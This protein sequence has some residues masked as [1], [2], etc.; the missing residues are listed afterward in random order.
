MATEG[1]ETRYFPAGTTIFREGDRTGREAF[2]I[3][4]GCVEIR[5]I[6][7]GLPHVLATLGPDRLFGEMA[8]IDGAPRA[9]T[10]VAKA[11]TACLVLPSKVFE[12]EMARQDAFMRLVIQGLLNNLRASA[13]PAAAPSSPGKRFEGRVNDP[14]FCDP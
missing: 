2:I 4:R 10:A 3:V 14:L 5:R 12:R 8:L 9:A 11:D 1:I 7:K 13:E 6:I